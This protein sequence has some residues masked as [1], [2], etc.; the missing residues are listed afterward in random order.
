MSG[1]G[2]D[3]SPFQCSRLLPGRHETRALPFAGMSDAVGVCCAG[4][5]ALAQLGWARLEF[6]FVAGSV[7]KEEARW[8]RPT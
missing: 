4:A 5:G 8:P 7:P 6:G 2:N 3:G 1:E